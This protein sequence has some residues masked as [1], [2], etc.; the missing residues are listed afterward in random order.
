MKSVTQKDRIA[1]LRTKATSRDDGTFEFVGS[2]PGTDRA[3]DEIN[4]KGW[5]VKS[6]MRNPV[7]LY[8]HDYGALPVGRTESLS[9]KDGNLV[10]RVRF[11]SHA[12]AQEVKT[13]YA[14]GV[15]TAV[16]V[17]FKALDTERKSDGSGYRIN[18]AELLEL[19]CVPVPCNADALLVGKAAGKR[20]VAVGEKP[21]VAD[22]AQ[23]PIIEAWVK[24]AAAE[25]LPLEAVQGG[26]QLSAD[27]PAWAKALAADVSRIKAA[28]GIEDNGDEPTADADDLL[29]PDEVDDSPDL[30]EALA[31]LSPARLG[32]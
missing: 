24:E 5:D 2:T 26:V 11:A 27:P 18:R 19:S 6:Y 7:V 14:E 15:L 31:A 13:L 21:G 28:L 25:A 16:S 1:N 4:Q 22:D 17:G 3:G 30:T 8:G 9:I 29:D 32:D 20:M 10:F 23:L 12:F